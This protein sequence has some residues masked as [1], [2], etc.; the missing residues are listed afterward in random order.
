MN[1][2]SGLL[3]IDEVLGG[4]PFSTEAYCERT[5]ASAQQAKDWVLWAPILSDASLYKSYG[6]GEN[7]EA[8]NA[9]R[10]FH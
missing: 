8:N 7:G 1:F 4:K 5:Y 10:N 3:K 9:I 2:E 6:E